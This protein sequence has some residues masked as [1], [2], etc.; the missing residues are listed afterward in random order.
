[1]AIILDADVIIRGQ[2][3]TFDLKGW[4]ASR[5]EDSF[6]VAA[7]TVAERW[8]GVQRAKGRQR[9]IRQ[10]YLQTILSVLPVVPDSAAHCVR[11]CVAVGATA[12]R[13]HNDR[14]LRP[15]RGRHRV[16]AGL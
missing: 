4:T 11:A 2:K 3:G 13:G 15:N 8:Y 5:A 16:G 1:M 6:E 10:R 14:L 9:T 12:I 7:I